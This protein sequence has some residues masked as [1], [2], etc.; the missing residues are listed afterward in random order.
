MIP[1]IVF[2]DISLSQDFQ[3]K[4][5]IPLSATWN[6]FYECSA[7]LFPEGHRLHKIVNV[8]QMLKCKDPIELQ[9]FASKMFCDV[10]YWCGGK[11][12]L[13][14]VPEQLTKV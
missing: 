4:D 1:D 2:N 6:L 12:S 10:C 3:F 5:C 14:E 11:N 7:V 8:K 13:C 9:Y